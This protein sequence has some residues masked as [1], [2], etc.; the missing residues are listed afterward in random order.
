MNGNRTQAENLADNS[1][2]KVAHRAYSEW[3]KRS[4]VVEACLP[5]LNY[6]ANQMFWIS[7]ASNWCRQQRPEFL[8]NSVRRDT[9]SPAVARVNLPLSNIR[10]FAEDFS[11]VP[12][13]KINP[14]DKCVVW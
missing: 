5:G 11:C 12:G 7:A 9:H 4:N 1:G 10:Q 14:A 2:Y 6:T 13:S 3:S 8:R